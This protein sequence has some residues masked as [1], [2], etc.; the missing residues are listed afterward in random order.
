MVA[1]AFAPAIYSQFSVES[2]KTVEL[3]MFLCYNLQ[4]KIV[5]SGKTVDFGIKN[6]KGIS[7]VKRKEVL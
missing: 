3:F 4:S 2:K 7:L 5:P 1:G 6:R